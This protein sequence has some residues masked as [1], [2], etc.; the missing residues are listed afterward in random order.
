MCI[1]V[2]LVILE[3]VPNVSQEHTLNCHTEIF[4]LKKENDSDAVSHM[5]DKNVKRPAITALSA[6]MRRITKYKRN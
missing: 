5:F 2:S 3:I 1:T 6:L 4:R